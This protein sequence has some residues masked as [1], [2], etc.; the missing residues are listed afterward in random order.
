MSK[1]FVLDSLPFGTDYSPRG[2][3]QERQ[4]YSGT[5]KARNWMYFALANTYFKV[6]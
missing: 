3:T 6:I 2:T 5:I 1:K 4:G